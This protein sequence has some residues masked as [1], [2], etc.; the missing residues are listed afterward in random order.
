MRRKRVIM[1][2]VGDDFN[3]AMRVIDR[4]NVYVSRFSDGVCTVFILVNNRGSSR[5][6]KFIMY[7]PDSCG[8]TRA[9][10]NRDEFEKM[11]T[12]ILSHFSRGQYE[13][14][15]NGDDMIEHFDS[16]CTGLMALEMGSYKGYR[17]RRYTDE[18]LREMSPVGSRSPQTHFGRR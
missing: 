4:G 9:E 13:F 12:D 16:I 10:L 6:L 14:E 2:F 17:V 15:E 3:S 5:D 1:H 11:F 8:F 7:N 18:E